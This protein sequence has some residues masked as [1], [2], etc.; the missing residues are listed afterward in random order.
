MMPPAASS[1]VRRQ[2]GARL[3]RVVD[4]KA[5]ALTFRDKGSSGTQIDVRTDSMSIGHIGKEMFSNPGG[6]RWRWYLKVDPDTVP[7]GCT[8]MASKAG[9]IER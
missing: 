5:M 1:G 6:L 7:P 9:L 8:R 3:S 4:D 2:P